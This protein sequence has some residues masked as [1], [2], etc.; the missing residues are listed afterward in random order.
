MRRVGEHLGDLPHLAD[1]LATGR[2]SLDKVGSVLGVAKPENEAEWAEAAAELSFKDLRELV[3]SKKPPTKESDRAD[4]DKR[5]LRFNDA[6]R[7]LVA[8]LPAAL[9]RPGALRAREAGQED[10]FRR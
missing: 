8:Q 5:S 6:L 2:V 9:L 3:R 4:Q 7:T 10:R 1:A